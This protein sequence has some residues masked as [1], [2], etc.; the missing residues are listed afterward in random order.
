[1]TYYYSFN[2]TLGYMM[3]PALNVSATYAR[4]LL[5]SNRCSPSALLAGTGLNAAQLARHDYLDW[6]VM[7]SLLRNFDRQQ[8]QPSWPA[9]LGAQFNMAAH[10]PL[11]FAALSAPTLEAALEVMAGFT[12]VRLTTAI[13]ATETR[14]DRFLLTMRDATGDALF[15]HWIEA[16]VFKVLESLLGAILGHPVGA[17][18]MLTFSGPAPPAA[19]ALAACYTARVAFA[20]PV[21]AL[22]VPASWLALPSPLH[23][24]A[25]YRGNLARCRDILASRADQM[26]VP[27]R[28]QM[29]LRSHFDASRLAPAPPPTLEQLAAQLHLTPRTLIR[30]LQHDGGSYRDTLDQLR[31]RY[32]AE[33]L[34]EARYTVADVAEILGYREQA[35]FGRAFRRWFGLSPS[36]WRRQ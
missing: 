22:S 11:G 29:L 32:A 2:D 9:E 16:I 10:G 34:R 36:A 27:Q 3:T 4:L 18:V 1:M 17:N 21:A 14:A 12:P 23:D 19:E 31:Q 13:V 30:R 26:S 15:A 8:A 24:E 35:N 33:L 5:H 25:V 6:Q 20:A 7:A 28:V